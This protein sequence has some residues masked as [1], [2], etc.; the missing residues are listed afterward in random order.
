[1]QTAP[2]LFQFCLAY[3]VFVATEGDRFFIFPALA[4]QTV[5]RRKS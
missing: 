1:M 3:L 2:G 5:N 4:K